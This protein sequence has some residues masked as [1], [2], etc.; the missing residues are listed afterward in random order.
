MPPDADQDRGFSVLLEHRP[1][2]VAFVVDLDSVNLDL[3]DAIVDFNVDSWGGRFNPII[4]SQNK[5]ICPDYWRLLKLADADLIYSYAE[6]DQETIERLDW[7]CGP[8]HIVGNRRFPSAD[9]RDYRPLSLRDQASITGLI[10]QFKDLIPGVFRKHKEPSILTF[11]IEHVN[12]RKISS[13]V[14]RNFGVSHKAYFAVRDEGVN[15]TYPASFSDIDVLECIE[16]ANN[17]LLPINLSSV[18]ARR[19]QAMVTERDESFVILYGDH[20]SNAVN[21]WN[22]AYFRGLNNWSSGIDDMWL[23]PSLLA[24]P[25]S[26]DALIKTIRRRVFMSGQRALK[27][28]SCDHETL[29]LSEIAKKISHDVKTNFYPVQ[30]EKVAQDFFPEFTTVKPL[31]FNPPKPR[32]EF[33]RGR[34]FFVGVERPSSLVVER[35]EHWMLRLWI[36]NPEQE[37]PYVNQNAWW[38]LPRRQSLARLFAGRYRRSRIGREGELIVEVESTEQNCEITIPDKHALFSAALLPEMEHWTTDDLRHGIP[39]SNPR[40]AIGHSDKGKYLNG[41]FSLFGSM[42]EATYFFEHPF[43]SR[44]LTELCRPEV[45]EQVKNQVKVAISEQAST[46][47]RDFQR[48][49]DTAVEWLA[50]EVIQAGQK[51]PRAE[52][53]LRFDA[54]SKSQ[55][56]F[57]A[58]AAPA[59]RE[60]ANGI[61]LEG[62][63]FTL[64]KGNALLQGFELRCHHCMSKFWYHIDDVKKVVDCIGCRRPIVLP[65]ERPWSYKPNELLWK[66][67]RYHGL[68]PVVRTLHRIFSETKTGFSFATGVV[69]LDYTQNPPRSTNEIDITWIR[70]GEFGIAEVKQ[71]TGLFKTKDCE[72][73]ITLAKLARP[74]TVLLVAME[75]EDAKLIKWQQVVDKEL[76]PLGIKTEAWGPSIFS[77]PSHHFW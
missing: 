18:G 62:D 60:R 30:G 21:Y 33:V 13:F 66:A 67:V 2:C 7:E 48:D 9:P 45:S 58:N 50:E 35:D 34:R 22:R 61:D 70:D 74:A 77:V 31:D 24:D 19:L 11:D 68:I 65:V 43:W 75:G 8:V 76:K 57:A 16:K 3:I 26:Y 51:I 28:I 71:S 47:V 37:M 27:I 53:L 40:T 14:R 39:R 1:C 32:H 56:E 38:T 63:L 64:T 55:T 49:P 72:R 52:N 23:P 10:L 15:P 29:E 6:L 20:L 36:Q 41:L 46:F 25:A 69:M 12:E 73:L 59:D 17:L 42:S 54:L 44:T 5:K 4:L